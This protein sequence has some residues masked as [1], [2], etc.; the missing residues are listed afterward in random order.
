[1]EPLP[2]VTLDLFGPPHH[3]VVA[4]IRADGTPQ[5][6]PVEITQEGGIPSFNTARGRAKITNLERDPRCTLVVIDTEDP[7]RYIQVRGRARIVA[8]DDLAHGDAMAHRYTGQPF[9]ELASGEVRVAVHI[10]PDRVYYRTS[11]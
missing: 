11:P 9:R 1:M 10:E 3:A 5:L 6:S 7:Q 4:T 8:D 2:V